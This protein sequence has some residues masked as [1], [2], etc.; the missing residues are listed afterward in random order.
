M[1]KNMYPHDA[2]IFHG[3]THEL[4]ALRYAA[5][6]LKSV[7]CHM[8]DRSNLSERSEK[9]TRYRIFEKHCNQVKEEMAN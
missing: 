3:P 6:S 1:E 4:R 8:M 2:G 7:P 9:M 5:G